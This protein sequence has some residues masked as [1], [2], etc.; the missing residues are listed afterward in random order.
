MNLLHEHQKVAIVAIMGV[1]L[2]LLS[3]IFARKSTIEEAN[4]KQAKIEQR[5]VA[6]KDTADTGD[7]DND[8]APDWQEILYGTDPKNPDST[9]T[10]IGDKQEIQNRKKAKEQ[11]FSKN[12]TDTNGA[13]YATKT[14]QTADKLIGRYFVAQQ[15]QKGVVT[16]SDS[17]QIVSRAITP[18]KELPYTHYTA[19]GQ[20]TTADTSPAA[21]EK[22][23][24]SMRGL[25]ATLGTIKEYEL[26]TYARAVDK[27]DPNEFKKLI[28]ASGTYSELAKKMSLLVVPKDVAEQHANLTDAFSYTATA[29]GAM[30]KGY[31]DV[32]NSY[33]ALG[34]FG[35]AEEHVKLAFEELKIYFLGKQ[36]DS[37]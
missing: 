2:I 5:A 19:I 22:Y 29:L 16:K 31:D 15:Q 7:A 9:G 18:L 21:A 20:V 30:G 10:G 12:T 26:Q 3:G 33:S 8:G 1:T 11:E 35:K 32:V 4:I 17:D 37:L 28:A 24:N 25:L 6:K 13:N 23:K 36:I 27:N 34:H 14:D